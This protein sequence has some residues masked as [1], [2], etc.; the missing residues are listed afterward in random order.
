M[1]T[2]LLIRNCEFFFNFA[3]L[4]IQLENFLSFFLYSG[5]LISKG[6]G[7]F[8]FFLKTRGTNECGTELTRCAAMVVAYCAKSAA[9]GAALLKWLA[10]SLVVPPSLACAFAGAVAVVV[11]LCLPPFAA[12]K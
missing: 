1:I 2:V 3:V 6:G 5:I 10:H 4:E 9:D 7:D 8:A 11:R 12:L